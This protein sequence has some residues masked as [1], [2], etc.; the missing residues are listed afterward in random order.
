ML[1]FGL[2][3]MMFFFALA[4]MFLGLWIGACLMMAVG[5]VLILVGYMMLRANKLEIDEV[6]KE[7]IV[8]V[9]CR[10]CGMLND[11]DDDRCA[12]CGATL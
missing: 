7:A 10:Y 4:P 8:K 9:K 5:L 3:F 6:R 1:L 11:T 2:A 12:S